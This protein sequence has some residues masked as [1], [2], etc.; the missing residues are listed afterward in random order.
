MKKTHLNIFF[1]IVAFTLI[2]KVFFFDEVE[3]DKLLLL[4]ADKLILLI[5]LAVIFGVSIIINFIIPTI[6]KN[7][8]SNNNMIPQQ[9]PSI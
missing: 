5:I 3:Y 4:K 8:F 7:Y 6:K 1:Q 9:V 2:V